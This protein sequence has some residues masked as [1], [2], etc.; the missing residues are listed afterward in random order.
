MGADR[1]RRSFDASRM[2]R[3]VVS[4]QGRVTLEADANEAEEI[5]TSESRAEL[6]DIVGP[7]GTS[8]DG[9]RI[10][11]SGGGKP[12]DFGISAGTMYIGGNR[13]VQSEAT[14]YE[15]QRGSEWVD[16]PAG[17]PAPGPGPATLMPYDELVYLV[18][19]EQE[20]SATEDRVLREIALGGPDTAARTRL[21]QRV[22][23]APAASN[24]CEASLAAAMKDY[25]LDAT[26]ARLTSTGQL[27][28]GLVPVAPP[29][30]ECEPTAQAGFL[31]AENQLIRVQMTG[32]RSLLWGY[33][34]ASF[35]YR[36]RVQAGR[37][38]IE[39]IGHPVDAFH[40]PRPDQWVEVLDIAVQLDAGERLAAAVGV[41]F[42]LSSYDADRNMIGLPQQVA[43]LEKAEVFVR[44]WENNLPFT[45][46]GTTKT[47]LVR[48]EGDSTGLWV[49]TKGTAVPGDHWMVG[50]R[51]SAPQS[52]LPERLHAGFCRPDGPNRWATPLAVLE[53]QDQTHAR[54]HDCRLPFD[55]LVELTRSQC[56]ELSLKPGDD[57]QRLVDTGIRA[58]A[59]R[60]GL[61]VRFVAGRFALEAPLVFRALKRGNLTITGCGLATEISIAGGESAIITTGWQRTTVSDLMLRG[62]TPLEGSAQH[63]GG[64]LTVLESAST[65][66][67]HV[68]A[69]CAGASRRRASCV[70]VRNTEPGASRARVSECDLR[71]GTNQV[72]AL[73]V[74]TAH[75]CVE[76]NVV[77]VS[78]VDDVPVDIT[79]RVLLSNV[80]MGMTDPWGDRYDVSPSRATGSVDVGSGATLWFVTEPGLVDLWSSVID[81]WAA[82]NE[83]TATERRR[84]RQLI[85]QAL[86]QILH[87][88]A[89]GPLHADQL[90]Q[91]RDWIKTQIAHPPPVALAAGQGIVV[92]GAIADDVRVLHNKITGATEGIRVG[93]STHADRTEHLLADRVQIVGNTID[94]LVPLDRSPAH[95]GIFVGNVQSATIR[96]NHV[97]CLLEE[98]KVDNEAHPTTRRA[99]AIRV[100]GVPGGADGHF[101]SIAGNISKHA[102]IGINV[103]EISPPPGDTLR[104]ISENLGVDVQTH[105]QAPP[106]AIEVDNVP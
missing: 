85:S 65:L 34:N 52:I 35:L 79:R 15:G 53:W 88:S 91:F 86:T 1:A 60:G 94:H 2:Y 20:V 77:A 4:Q 22:M 82:A 7:A 23:R 39:L 11:V 45:G 41:P 38:S 90:L 92:A 14:T 59:A 32:D 64:A 63:I 43:Q 3:S 55:T 67:D 30:D 5:R 106:G 58:G 83:F 16:Y 99:E 21:V 101:L 29:D 31:G 98:V 68:V 37:T 46:D 97:R 48:P 8:D 25:E 87:P 93:L 81:S 96:D 26:T 74:N 62:G 17:S 42:Q 66:V 89:G 40:Q 33:D 84:L 70:T 36:G 27:M 72:G 24:D 49:S 69:T 61:H 12:F 80:R 13:V 54:V 104:R 18:V 10:T 76:H 78:T 75:A 103:V 44:M 102:S 57:L 9:F 28:V 19:S 50:V 56:C 51:P 100:W 73:L 105:I 95:A 47:E 71:V 6:V